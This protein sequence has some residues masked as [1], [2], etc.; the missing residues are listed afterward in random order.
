V[1]SRCA[2]RP[3]APHAF[4]RRMKLTRRPQ[5]QLDAPK[6]STKT[7]TSIADCL[8]DLG[9]TR[10]VTDRPEASQTLQ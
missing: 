10:S 5:A 2:R 8:Y 4:S 6:S 1:K 9:D 3:P 7:E